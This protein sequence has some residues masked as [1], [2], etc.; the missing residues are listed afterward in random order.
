MR[1]PAMSGRAR[2]IPVTS[3]IRCTNN[4]VFGDVTLTPVKWFSFSKRRQCDSAEIIPWC[5]PLT[6]QPLRRTNYLN[7]DTA[8]VTIHPARQW[9]L[10]LTAA[11]VRT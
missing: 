9:T 2:R 4:R 7:A 11:S 3:R 10:P 8:F 5:F 1:G 6:N